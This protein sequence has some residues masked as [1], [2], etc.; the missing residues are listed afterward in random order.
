MDINSIKD[1][2]KEKL[3]LEGP[4]GVFEDLIRILDHSAEIFNQIEEL[5]ADYFRLRKSKGEDETNLDKYEE[6][7]RELNKALR[8]LIDAIHDADLVNDLRDFDPVQSEHE[9]ADTAFISTPIASLTAAE[10]LGMKELAEDLRRIL[11]SNPYNFQAVYYPGD[12]FKGVEFGTPMDAI[13]QDFQ[14]MCSAE[15]FIMI[16]PG[17]MVSSALVLAGYALALRKK[18]RFFV[19]KRED[20]PYILRSSDKVFRNVRIFEYGSIEDIPGLLKTHGIK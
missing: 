16:Y 3:T 9:Q 1:P 14:H 10:Y 6:R 20:L 13:K 19:K 8:K 18:C 4:E 17:G 11:L 5:R 12:N 2:L 7:M 15:F